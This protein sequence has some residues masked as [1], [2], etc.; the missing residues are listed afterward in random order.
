MSKSREDFK[1][2]LATLEQA[3][4]QGDAKAI[5]KLKSAGKL[6]CRER[7]HALLDPGSFVEE[8]MLAETQCADFGM[9]ERK[10]PS[11]GVVTG[12]GKI[13]GRPVYVFAQDRSILAGTVGSAHAERSPM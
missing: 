4:L 3:A 5:A 6:T 12:I 1:E 9:A 10:R 13:E 7:I 8:F 2:R 11:D